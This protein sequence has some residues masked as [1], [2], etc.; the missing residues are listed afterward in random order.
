MPDVGSLDGSIEHQVRTRGDRV[1]VHVSHGVWY[2]AIY[3][4]PSTDAVDRPGRC[5]FAVDVGECWVLIPLAHLLEVR[6]TT[7]EEVLMKTNVASD[8]N[9]GSSTSEDLS[10]EDLVGFSSCVLS[11]KGRGPHREDDMLLWLANWITS[12]RLRRI[13]MVQVDPSMCVLDDDCTWEIPK[14]VV[15]TSD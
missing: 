1:D 9:L 10:D 4:G 8:T 11:E 2:T 7:N 3:L 15:S 6:P 5:M 12:R 13:G 14:D